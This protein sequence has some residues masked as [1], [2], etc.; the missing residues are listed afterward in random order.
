MASRVIFPIELEKNCTDAGIYETL[1][2]TVMVATEAID[3][4]GGIFLMWLDWDQLLK[5]NV[6]YEHI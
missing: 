6:I 1:L 3:G 4:N 2:M 5:K